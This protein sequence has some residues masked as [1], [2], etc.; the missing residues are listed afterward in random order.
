MRRGLR[1][2]TTRV[3]VRGR[4]RLVQAISDHL[5]ADTE[6]FNCGSLKVRV[7]HRLAFSR[8]VYYGVYEEHLIN[9]IARNLRPGDQV[10]EPGTNIG[11]VASQILNAVG[12]QGLLV[13]LEPS[14]TCCA[15]IGEDNALAQRKD[16]VLLNA[17]LSRTSGAEMYYESRRIVSRGYGCLESAG[18]PADAVRYEIDTYS[19]DDLV[20]RFQIDRVRFLKLDIEGSELPALEGAR[21]TLA[22]GKIDFIMVETEIDPASKPQAEVNEK[23]AAILSQAGFAPYWMNRNGTLASFDMESA[24]R[25]SSRIRTDLLWSRLP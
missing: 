17:A 23:I 19:I 16:F 3:P 24:A 18:Q 15:A 25:G 8:A 11:F 13:S 4:H 22:A 20:V 2:L 5:G 7:D 12:P 14:R 6:V 1:A 9:W 10:I 21:H